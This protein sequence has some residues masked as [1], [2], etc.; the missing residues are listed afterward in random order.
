MKSLENRFPPPFVTLFTCLAMGLIAWALPGWI[1][2]TG[3][4]MEVAGAALI[5][6]L[7]LLMSAVLSFRK[8]KTTINPVHIDRA[9]SIVTT[10]IFSFTRNPMYLGMSIIITSLAIA[11][12]N[13]WFLLGTVFFIGFITRFQI[14]PEERVML[15][16]FGAEYDQYCRRVRRWI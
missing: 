15:E 12:G 4:S 8:A 10:G 7:F 5:V 1:S 3:T 16:K 9:S 6:G 2:P 13:L 14:F 11:L